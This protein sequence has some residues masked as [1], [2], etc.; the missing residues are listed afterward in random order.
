[1]N[2]MTP[3][4]SNFYI[5]PFQVVQYWFLGNVKLLSNKNNARLTVRIKDDEFWW[6]AFY[7]MTR[8]SLPMDAK[9]IFYLNYFSL[10]LVC[11]VDQESFLW[12]P[13]GS[14]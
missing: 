4:T 9:Y 5:Q 3:I 7:F 11:G 6:R 2:E 8:S 1:M 13:G 12:L 10:I 14:R